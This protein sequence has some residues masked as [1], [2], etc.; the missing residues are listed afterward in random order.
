[1]SRLVAFGAASGP[2][3]AWP[4]SPLSPAVMAVGVS[5]QP[6]TADDAPAVPRAAG[7]PSGISTPHQAI[8]DPLG[9]LVPPR[10]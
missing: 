4:R 3:G 9:D 2:P 5:G 1:M 7:A 8:D 10:P 6:A